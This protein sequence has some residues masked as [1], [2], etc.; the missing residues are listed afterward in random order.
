MQFVYLYSQHTLLC[1]LFCAVISAVAFEFV[2]CLT[3]ICVVSSCSVNSKL[4]QSLHS[5][6]DSFTCKEVLK[7]SN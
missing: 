6:I 1:T 3:S 2:F 7:L 5:T 4:E